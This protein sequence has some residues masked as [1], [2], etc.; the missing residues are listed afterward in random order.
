MDTGWP[1]VIFGKMLV[2]TCNTK[3]THTH[4]LVNVIWAEWYYS[5]IQKPEAKIKHNTHRRKTWEIT[6]SIRQSQSSDEI[7]FSKPNIIL[8]SRIEGLPAPILKTFM[9]KKIKVSMEILGHNFTF[10]NVTWHTLVLHLSHPLTPLIYFSKV[11]SELELEVFS[12][13]N[14]SFDAKIRWKIKQNYC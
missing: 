2:E 5:Y 6:I 3:S 12:P 9:A 8:T 13:S 10:Y 14:V 4:K 7:V 11:M 1:E